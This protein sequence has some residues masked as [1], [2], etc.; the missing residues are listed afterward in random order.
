MATAGVAGER[1]LLDLKYITYNNYYI[2]RLAIAEKS[3][4]S[5]WRRR[6]SNKFD[7]YRI[8]TRR[9]PQWCPPRISDAGVLCCESGSAPSRRSRF[10]LQNSSVTPSSPRRR[11]PGPPEAA[12]GRCRA[13]LVGLSISAEVW[14]AIILYVFYYISRCKPCKPR[15]TRGFLPPS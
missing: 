10:R 3:P 5:F 8:W 12:D 11:P 9:D 1:S 13:Y 4:G 7:S 2:R 15:G 14:N 6:N